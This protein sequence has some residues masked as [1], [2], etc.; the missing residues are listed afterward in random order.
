MLEKKVIVSVLKSVLV[1]QSNSAQHWWMP[2]Q[3]QFACL[4]W[5][6][7]GSDPWSAEAAAWLSL[8]VR[9]NKT[10]KKCQNKHTFKQKYLKLYSH[11]QKLSEILFWIN[12]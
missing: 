9:T 10:K 1:P 11:S 3:L 5:G 7:P 2:H 4:R 8:G 12:N 6:R